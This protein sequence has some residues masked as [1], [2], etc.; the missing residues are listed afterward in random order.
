MIIITA[1]IVRR[2]KRINS[3]IQIID[4]PSDDPADWSTTG[5]SGD[6]LVE[7]V[8]V[9]VVVTTRTTVLVLV[10]MAVDVNVVVVV[11]VTSQV[12]VRV[13]CSI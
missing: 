5:C 9:I 3:D 4:V 11:L 2:A 13:K 12:P 7:T 6:E 10:V 1:T 8:L